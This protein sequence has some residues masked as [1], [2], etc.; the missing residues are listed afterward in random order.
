MFVVSHP[1]VSA[2]NPNLPVHCAIEEGHSLP[3]V[4]FLWEHWPAEEGSPASVQFRTGK[5]VTALH[6]AAARDAPSLEHVEFVFRLRPQMLLEVDP[7]GRLP[8]HYAAACRHPCLD[9]C[10]LLV[11]RSPASL[12]HADSHGSLPLH[13]CV[14]RWA[15]S[16]EKVRYLVGQHPR[17]LQVKNSKGSLPLHVALSQ[18]KVSFEVAELLVE[19]DPQ[20][21]RQKDGRGLLPLHVAAARNA[22]LDVLYYLATKDPGS[23][24]K[25]RPSRVHPIRR[26]RRQPF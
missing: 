9:V 7:D 11:E 22:E 13:L 25:E 3:T 23:V 8:V 6:L 10:R 26:K 12:G 15:P 5:G 16:L 1:R 20:S 18:F 19:H 4:E 2:R 17:A 14:D 21:L 24:F